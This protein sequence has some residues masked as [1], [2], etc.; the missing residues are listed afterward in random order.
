MLKSK[1]VKDLLPAQEVGGV[2]EN[3]ERIS[4]LFDRMYSTAASVFWLSSKFD[5]PLAETGI[6]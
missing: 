1:Y 6:C 2:E 4:K 5:L 3:F